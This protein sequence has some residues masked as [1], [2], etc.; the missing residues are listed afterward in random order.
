MIKR[1][2]PIEPR[3]LE[4]V[5]RSTRSLWEH[6]FSERC[7]CQGEISVRDVLRLEAICRGYRERFVMATDKLAKREELRDVDHRA[8]ETIAYSSASL[9]KIQRL[10]QD[11]LK[12]PAYWTELGLNHDA[13]I[14]AADAER[15][16]TTLKEEI[17]DA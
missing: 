14:S 13:V 9:K 7:R 10:C 1:P 6:L 4:K 8:A 3:L 12:N 11:I 2:N 16:R 17:A 15:L 5:S